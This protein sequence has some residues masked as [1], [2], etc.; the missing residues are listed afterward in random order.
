M[1][2]Q[3]YLRSRSFFFTL[4]ASVII[5]LNSCENNSLEREMGTTLFP[6]TIQNRDGAA[7]VKQFTKQP[8]I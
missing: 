4:V 2:K 7:L 3:F 1:K 8:G 6:T 5:L